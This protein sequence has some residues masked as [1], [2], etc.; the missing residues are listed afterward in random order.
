MVCYGPKNIHYKDTMSLFMYNIE[1]W[2][3]VQDLREEGWVCVDLLSDFGILTK[4]SASLS[5]QKQL[6]SSLHPLLRIM[7]IK[8]VN[9]HK[10]LKKGDFFYQLVIEHLLY[11]H[12][13]CVLI[14]I[15]DAPENQREIYKFPG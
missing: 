11:V 8:W 13:N 6:G 1:K 15:Y 9:T 3:G 7:R 12:S 14:A 4:T 2:L 5:L 10:V